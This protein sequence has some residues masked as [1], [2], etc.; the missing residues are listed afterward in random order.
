MGAVD[1]R[2]PCRIDQELQETLDLP[3]AELRRH[4]QSLVL[5]KYRLLVKV[6]SRRR[7]PR[8]RP[9]PKAGSLTFGACTVVGC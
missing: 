7:A 8:R 4:V 1:V 5:G 6:R 3:E 2:P 9:A